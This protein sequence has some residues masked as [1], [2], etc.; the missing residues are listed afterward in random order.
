MYPRQLE[1]ACARIAFT[2]H[3]VMHD[4]RRKFS[5]EPYINHPRRVAKIVGEYD[6]SLSCTTFGN[7]YRCAAWLH[8]VVEDCGVSIPELCDDI[9]LEYPQLGLSAP[10]VCQ[11]ILDMVQMLTKPAVVTADSPAAVV[12]LADIM[13]NTCR[14]DGHQLSKKYLVTKLEQAE[15]LS[16]AWPALA[17]H[18]S[19]TLRT[20][21]DAAQCSAT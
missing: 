9:F 7:L 20:R 19:I 10:A 5:N 3:Q 4:Q 6:G 2:H 14:K 12:K 11:E 13:D 16:A 1:V 21:V 18:I 15:S 17:S 8:D